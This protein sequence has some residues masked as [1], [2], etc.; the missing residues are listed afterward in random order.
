MNSHPIKLAV[1][2]LGMASKPHLAALKQLEPNIEIVGLYARSPERR[3]EAAT[4]WGWPI[5]ESLDDIA[6]S[7]ADGAILITPPNARAEL[8]A[9]L[10]KAGKAILMEKPVERDLNRATK[11]VETC[12]TA[13]VPLG[14]VLQHRFRAGAEALAKVIQSGKA[15]RIHMVRVTL[16]WWRDQAYYDQPGRGTYAS[17]GGGVLITQAI[18]V[19]DLMLSLTGPVTE[20]AA[21]SGTTE[22][23]QMEAEDFATAGLRFANGAVGSIVAT[24]SAF[25]GDAESLILDCDHAALHLTAGEL[26]IHWRDGRTETVGEITGTGG[27]GDPMD[28]PCD[29]HRD[30]IADFADALRTGTSPRITGREA[31]RVHRLIDAIERSVGDGTLTKIEVET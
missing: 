23:H 28:F 4:D 19:L 14:I 7:N 24:T 11:I 10:A 9:T 27:G 18:H 16:P 13:G 17:D 20:V 1:I 12:E 31:L 8:V 29:W 3:Q 15:G 21:F 5:F 30:L 22:L 6:N 26:M 2:G 25:P